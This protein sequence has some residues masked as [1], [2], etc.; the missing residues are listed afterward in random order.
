MEE[1]T[2]INYADEAFI[3]V[4]SDNQDE[5]LFNISRDIIID[6]FYE[7]EGII[8]DIYADDSR[9]MLDA[10]LYNCINV[11]CDFL[12]KFEVPYTIVQEDH[13]IDASYRDTFYHYYSNQH[14]K[15]RR[16]SRRLSFFNEIITREQ[17]FSYD[18]DQDE[19]V[20]KDLWVL[21]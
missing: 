6:T 16:Y 1:H 9:K 21:V 7:D 14:F 10:N 11:L 19:N 5:I 17:F 15:T 20:K 13:H 2:Q 12:K 4:T 8:S 3:S 18:L